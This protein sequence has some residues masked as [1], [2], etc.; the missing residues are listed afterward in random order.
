[1]TYKLTPEHAKLWLP[2][3]REL[4]EYYERKNDK[5]TV[6]GEYSLCE[7]ARKIRDRECLKY[8]NCL[9]CPAHMDGKCFFCLWNVFEKKKCN[10]FDENIMIKRTRRP[11]SWCKQSIVR[12][13]RWERRLEE[14][15]K[16]EKRNE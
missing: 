1:M 2:V 5:F 7:I 10:V 9:K 15:I 3:V 8:N 13:K 11:Q 4:R 16:E 6:V 14:I 12:L